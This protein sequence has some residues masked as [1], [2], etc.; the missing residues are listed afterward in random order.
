[1]TASNQKPTAY[2]STVG[3]RETAEDEVINES[4]NDVLNSEIGMGQTFNP[5]TSSLHQ[6][7]TAEVIEEKKVANTQESSIFRLETDPVSPH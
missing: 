3:G 1:M 7:P 4:R 6:E 5:V 2:T